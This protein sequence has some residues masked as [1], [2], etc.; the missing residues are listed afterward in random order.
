MMTY[1]YIWNK[2]RALKGEIYVLESKVR[3]LTINKEQADRLI[4]LDLE[5]EHLEK[6]ESIWNKY[7]ENGFN[8]YEPKQE[9][10][11]EFNQA[12]KIS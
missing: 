5:H 8:G 9:F 1:Y 12:K 11:N 3:D 2:M 7:G 6:I 4:G 10:I